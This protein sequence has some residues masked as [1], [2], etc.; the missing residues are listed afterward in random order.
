MS[1]SS[2]SRV[3]GSALVLST[4]AISLLV[5]PASAAGKTR[6]VDDDGKA[7]ASSCSGTKTAYKK[8]QSAVTASGAG[9]TVKVCPGTYVG[10][11]TIKGARNG[12]VL[13][14][15]TSTRRDHQ[16]RR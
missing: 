6:W 12:L 8:I 1:R 13:R 5:A 4:V 11:V 10:H 16:G 9:D 3:L 7:G 2:M 14:S 15:V